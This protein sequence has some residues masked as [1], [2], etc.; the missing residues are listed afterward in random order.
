MRVMR[1]AETL[2]CGRIGS[3]VGKKNKN[4]AMKNYPIRVNKK[5]IRKAELQLVS[6]KLKEYLEKWKEVVTTWVRKKF[7]EEEQAVAEFFFDFL[8]DVLANLIS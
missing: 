2:G 1:Q 7:L 5:L 3:P 8:A 4:S 6:V